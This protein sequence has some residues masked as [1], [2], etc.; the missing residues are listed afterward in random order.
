[1][2]T[3]DKHE[4]LA[5]LLLEQQLGTLNDAGVDEL[6]T[7]LRNDIEARRYYAQVMVFDAALKQ[8]SVAGGDIENVQPKNH[9]TELAHHE[10]SA[11][12]T[13]SFPIRWSS[14]AAALL[15]IGLAIGWM[16]NEF[17]QRN[18]PVVK[19]IS[20]EGT[21][22][23]TDDSVAMIT[24]SIGVEWVADSLI[25]VDASVR[26]G[27]LAITTGFLQIEFYSGARVVVQGPAD[28]E[29]ISSM[30]TVVH[31]G[32]IRAVVPPLAHGFTVRG[33][34]VKV[35]DL[36]T[37]FA[38]ETAADGSSQVHVFIGQVDLYSTI[39][40]SLS[41]TVKRTLNAG[42]AVR[43][44]VG[45]VPEDMPSDTNAF[46]SMS[47][48]Q[49]QDV[50]Q[51]QQRLDA[52]RAWHAARKTDPRLIACYVFDDVGTTLGTVTDDSEHHH[53]GT[54]VGCQLVRGRW[55]GKPAL[56]FK[57]PG[58][59]VRVSIPGQYDELTFAAWVRVDGIGDRLQ[60]IFLTDSF[61]IGRPHWQISETGTLR[62]GLRLPSEDKKTV[63]V[64]YASPIIFS[65][66]RIGL[67]SFV[68]TVYSRSDQTVCHY[69]NGRLMSKERLAFDQALT[70]GNGEIGNWGV[71][72][73]NNAS[74]IRN[75][76]GLIDELAIWKVPFSENEVRTM[77]L[78]GRP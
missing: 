40:D 27:R 46:A 68:C 2:S 10:F 3:P 78:A 31:A 25:N 51:S 41:K 64:G 11:R 75:F 48:L 6:R 7:I 43:L 54:M 12:R 61:E 15:L 38:F 18:E 60:G 39:S 69:L 28:L 1:M 36:G 17:G 22:E 55:Q 14:A 53:M 58:D 32:K 16:T 63:A 57:R 8:E 34:Q 49:Q 70:I 20:P 21:A 9:S 62:L 42:Q 26:P 33:P 35:I 50:T 23:K 59:R 72:I 52:W 30:E 19:L 44:Q 66:Q 71:P 29:I 74:P 73:K 13:V 37:D 5:E 45:Q 47:D 4:R 67:W 76:N 65:P 24:R 56:S 77:Y